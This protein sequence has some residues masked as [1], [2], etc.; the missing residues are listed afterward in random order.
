MVLDRIQ[1]YCKQNNM[2]I[3][4]FEKK[5][6][7]SNGTIG[8]WKRHKNNPSL[9]AIKKIAEITKIPIEQLVG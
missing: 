5:C 2:S 1:E 3:S 6:G 8:N 9:S 7:L 4:T